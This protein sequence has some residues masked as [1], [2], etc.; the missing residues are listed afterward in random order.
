LRVIA[1]SHGGRPL[2]APK[3]D[4]T[5]P[6]TDRVREALF[7][8][9][10]DLRGARVL[11]LY[12][13]TGALGIEALSRGAAHAVFVES[14]RPALAALRTNLTQLGLDAQATVVPLPILRVL[15]TLVAA[16]PFALILCDP[17]WAAVDGALDALLALAKAKAF[18]ESALVILEHAARTPLRDCAPLVWRE[19]RR[20]GDTALA[21]GG[22]APS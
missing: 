11:D 12:A 1:G 2:V 9:L 8:I 7:S 18:D 15:P 13:G 3:G 14:G 22:L 6:T 19:T 10:G 4:A 20:Y 5:R 21:L 16:G 17:P